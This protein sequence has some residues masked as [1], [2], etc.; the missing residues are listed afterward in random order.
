[1]D[2]KMKEVRVEIGFV[3]PEWIAYVT[4]DAD[5]DWFGWEEK[6]VI[7]F[8]ESRWV[9]GGGRHFIASGNDNNSWMRTLREVG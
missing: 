8:D 9:N 6:P 7:D 2:T 5:G 3:V 1:M 4:Q